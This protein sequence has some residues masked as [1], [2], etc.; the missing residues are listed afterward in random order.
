[1]L[2]LSSTWVHS[3]SLETSIGVTLLAG[4]RVVKDSAFV[5]DPLG[6]MT[7][8]ELRAEIDRLFDRE[9]VAGV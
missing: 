3:P 2:Y 4:M 8:A 9:V 5:A 1:M 7:L 6:G